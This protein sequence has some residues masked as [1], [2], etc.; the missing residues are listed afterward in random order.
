MLGVKEPEK[1][2]LK[3]LNDS[4]VKGTGCFSRMK[5]IAEVTA[6]EL[7]KRRKYSVYGKKEGHNSKPVQE[8]RHHPRNPSNNLLPSNKLLNL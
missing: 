5:P 1:V 7:S 6:K 2:Q 8:N 4:R 3:N